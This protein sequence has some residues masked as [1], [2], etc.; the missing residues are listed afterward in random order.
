[1]SDVVSIVE[2]PHGSAMALQFSL[3]QNYPNPFN[4]ATV[5]SFQLAASSMVSIKVYDVLGR[6]V[7]T[8]VNEYRRQGVHTVR[9]DAGGMSSGVYFYQIRSGSFLETKK[10]VFA[11]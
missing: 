6:L 9:W 1:M 2:P 10:L 7:A 11:K 5:I 4:G 3:A 8:L